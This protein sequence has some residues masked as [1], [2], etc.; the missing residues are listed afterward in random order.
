MTSHLELENQIAKLKAQNAQLTKDIGFANYERKEAFKIANMAVDENKA[1]QFENDVL[2]QSVEDLE[3]QLSQSRMNAFETEVDTDKIKKQS[4]TIRFLRQ[5]NEEYENRAN[6][7][8]TEMTEQMATLQEMA[9][10]RI[11]VIA[12]V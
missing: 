10:K 9:M 5:K 11:Q 8:V 12:I 1:L 4:A 3:M 6:T 2:N 7:M